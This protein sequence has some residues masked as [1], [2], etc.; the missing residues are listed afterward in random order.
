ML[1]G[2]DIAFLIWILGTPMTASE[3]SSAFLMDAAIDE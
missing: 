3:F 1:N 2:L